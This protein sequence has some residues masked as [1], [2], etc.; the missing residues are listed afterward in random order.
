MSAEK[1]FEQEVEKRLNEVRN[2]QQDASPETI[3]ETATRLE[4]LNYAPPVTIKLAVFLRLTKESLLG[5]IDRI[6]AMPDHE[7]CA[8]APDEPKKCEDLRLQFISV[9]IFYYRQ[10][11]Q[12][13]AGDPEAWDEVDEIYVHD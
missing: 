4:G 2:L 6:L 11:I 1:A 9:M 12:L 7:A 8:L 10:L 5:E 13:R 3:E